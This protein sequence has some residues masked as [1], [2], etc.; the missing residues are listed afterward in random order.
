MILR[1]YPKLLSAWALIM[2]AFSASQ[3]ALAA[4][5]I[6]ARWPQFRGPGGS[7][8]GS[9]DFPT[10]FGPDNNVVWK[11]A[12]P[13]G[14]SSPCIWNGKI[15]LTGFSEGKLETLCLDRNDGRVLW[16][17][18]IEPGS[19]ERGAPLSH[20]ATATTATDGE[21]V[22]VYFGSFGLAAYDFEGVELWRKPLPIPVT[23]HGAGT[24]PVL[25]GDLL[26]LNRDQDVGSHLLAVNKR[27]GQTVWQTERPGFHRGF[28]TPLPW[29]PEKPEQIIVPGS[30]RLVSYGLNNGSE[31]WTVRGLPN[32]M[33]SSPVSGDGMIFVAGWTYGSGV[34]RMPAF[35]RLLEQGDANKDGQLAQNEATG[36]PA[37]QHFLYI[38][39][40]KN[41]RITREEYAD[42]V[43]VFD[44]AK[45]VALAVRP[46]GHG[47]VTDTHVVWTATRGLPYVPSP[48]FF[49]GRLYLVRNGGMASCLDART[50]D[51]HYRDERLDALGDYYCSPVAASGKICVA[52][53][54]G[55][56]VVYRAGDTLEVLARNPLNEPV[57]ATPAIA[58]NKLYVRTRSLIYAFGEAKPRSPDK[59]APDNNQPTQTAP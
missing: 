59:N 51:Y 12:A 42:I 38:D 39:A 19:I 56:V 46:D 3:T 2:A 4:D 30:L 14:H 9:G 21:R 55:V 17:R 48:L 45:N 53:Q 34:S 27:N 25:A 23:Q 22:C 26:I 16:R 54:P 13:E 44:E 28:S 11:T 20:P 41:G 24:S 58:D 37:K 6:G 1:H 31:R 52:S 57:L 35:D 15:F 8:I 29:P 7:G 32:E 5:E 36:G 47:D 33:V 10:H 49:N 43:R 50:G 18:H 40:D